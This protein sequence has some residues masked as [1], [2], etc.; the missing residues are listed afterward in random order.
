MNSAVVN[1][2]IM[3]PMRFGESLLLFG[4]PTVVFF[5][6]TRILIPLFNDTFTVHPVLVWFLFGGVFLFIPLVIVAILC[7]KRDGYD[8]NLKVFAERFRLTG[9]TRTDWLWTLSALVIIMLLTGAIMFTW[10]LLSVHFGLRAM[11]TSAPFLHFDPLRG[12]ERLLLSVWIPFFFFNIVGEEL[13]WRGYI[14]PRQELVYGKSAWLINGALWFLFHICFGPDLLI[15][16]V[17][18]LFILPYA[19]QRRKNTTVGILIHGLVNGP[20]FIL[21]SLGLLK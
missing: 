13:L 17:P 6:I 18:V 3:K 20:S 1:G 15:M 14:L 10:R 5:I 19:V 16:L 8:F 9:L 21:I 2:G 12:T 7:F 4:F 11:D